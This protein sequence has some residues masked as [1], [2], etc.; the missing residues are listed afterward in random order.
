M[1]QITDATAK[2]IRAR[3]NRSPQLFQMFQKS[4]GTTQF[5]LFMYSGFFGGAGMSSLF[6]DS[7]VISY[8]V[9]PVRIV[10]RDSRSCYETSA[11]SIR[12]LPRVTLRVVDLVGI[13][14]RLGAVLT[15]CG[16]DSFSEPYG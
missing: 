10:N 11:S 7:S 13:I 4:H 14:D 12:H 16:D 6:F 2:A 3:I 8:V 1:K 5:F 9:Q 15:G